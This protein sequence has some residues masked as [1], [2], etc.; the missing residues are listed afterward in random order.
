MNDKSGTHQAAQ[1]EF[2]VKTERKA[3]GHAPN[4]VMMIIIPSRKLR[5]GSKEVTF[6]AEIQPRL[7]ED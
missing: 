5:C 6:S 4:Q 1:R 3:L 2:L 7:F